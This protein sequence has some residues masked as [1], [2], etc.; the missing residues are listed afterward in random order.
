MKNPPK[1]RTTW[2]PLSDGLEVQVVAPSRRKGPYVRPAVRHVSPSK[3]RLKQPAEEG[4]CY[5]GDGRRVP[6]C[7][8][9]EYDRRVAAL[10]ASGCVVLAVPKAKRKDRV[11]RVTKLGVGNYQIDFLRAKL[12]KGQLLALPLKKGR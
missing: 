9:A 5:R 2:K 11:V 7:G 4:W 3:K 8:W 12:M 10:R 6:F 1:K